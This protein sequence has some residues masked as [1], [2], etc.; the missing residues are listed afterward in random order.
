MLIRMNRRGELMT[1]AADES[2]NNEQCIAQMEQQII[3]RLPLIL[4]KAFE[5]AEGVQLQKESASGPVIYQK[6]P[7][8]VMV[9]HLIER[10]AGKAEARKSVGHATR[11]CSDEWW[12][13]VKAESSLLGFLQQGWPIIEPGRDFLSNWH[14]E[15]IAEHLE[16]VLRGDILRLIINQPP[17]SMKSTLVSIMWPVWAWI[18][19]PELR[20]MFASYAQSLSTFHS[21]QRR[22]IIQSDWYRQCWGNKVQLVS[23]QNQKTEYYN[24]RQ[25]MMIATSVGGTSI[26]KGGDILIFDDPL[27]P[28]EAAST[29][30]RES[31]NN[32]IRQGFLTRLND[33][34]CG[35]IVGVMQ[36]LHEQDTTGMLLEQGGWTHLCLPA[37]AEVRT[38][39]HFPISGRD[40]VR[41]AG[42]I[43][44]PER[45]G[46]D[47]LARKKVELGSYGYAGQY[48][49]RPSPAEGGVLKRHWWRFW[50]PTDIPAPAQVAVNMGDGNVW[51]CPQEPLPI[52]FDDT[53]NSWDMA[54]KDTDQA[55]YVVGQAWARKGAGKYLLEQYRQRADLPE[56]VR[57]VMKLANNFPANTVLIEDKANGPAVIQVL[58][59]TVP[60]I[61]TVN[62]QGGKES[63]INA[64][65]ATIEAGDVYLPHPTIAGWVNDFIERSAAFPNATYDDE[66]DAM[67]QA[68]MRLR[69][70]PPLAENEQEESDEERWQRIRRRPGKGDNKIG[71]ATGWA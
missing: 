43:L 71:G 4:E 53:C 50:Y 51:C 37:E 61:V 7:D 29:L 55:D 11:V 17:R 62:P 6:A 56:S 68:L 45:E 42:D 58:K 47:E 21:L 16:A 23:D 48:Q 28:T 59:Q 32:W 33:Q 13:R 27:N 26:G 15:C 63:R 1:D 44:F 31:A 38:L 12:Q 25:G 34:K 41:E 2:T 46:P 52:A 70:Y 30:Q 5:L 8:G 10:A 69:Y 36:R 54:F 20:F 57:L 67:S 19:H 24:T 14:I 35:R 18:A 40:I 60:G 39:I 9:R 3:D 22:L 49:Q 66:Q 64:V 65:A